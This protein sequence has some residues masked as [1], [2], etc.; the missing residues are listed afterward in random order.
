M[1]RADW[2]DEG[3]GARNEALEAGADLAALAA[4]EV[5]R[6]NHPAA[7]LDAQLE[8]WRHRAGAAGAQG[9][10]GSLENAI[11]QIKEVVEA[12]TQAADR[13]KEAGAL[14]QSFQ[15][16]RI[17]AQDA[18]NWEALLLLTEAETT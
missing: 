13:S 16:R 1:L 3:I 12:G 6:G 7:A 8:L 9:R 15:T 2:L 10:V 4:D 18:Q 14:L 17:A 11:E 5:A